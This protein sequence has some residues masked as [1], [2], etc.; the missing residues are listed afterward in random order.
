[1]AYIFKSLYV[2]NLFFNLLIII[3]PTLSKEYNN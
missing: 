1:M 3:I 2:Y